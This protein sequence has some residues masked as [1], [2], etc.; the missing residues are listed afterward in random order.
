MCGTQDSKTLKNYIIIQG[1]LGL[2]AKLNAS[3]KCWYRSSAKEN[4]MD[5]LE[6][7]VRELIFLLGKDADRKCRGGGQCYERK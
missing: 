3:I 6:E 4:N 7:V 2:V 5:Y 1:N